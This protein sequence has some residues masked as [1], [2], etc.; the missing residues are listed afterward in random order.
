[1]PYEYLEEGV[2]SDATFRAS[3]RDLNEL[4]TAAADATTNLMVGDL[5]ALMP[6]TSVPLDVS[7]DALDLL[8]VRF[9]EEIVFEKDAHALFLRATDVHVTPHGRG[10]RAR[11][12]LRGEPIDPAKHELDADV[13]AVTLH[14][15]AVERGADGWHAQVTVDV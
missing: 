9:L 8:L 2:T 12:V 7:A 15:L 1:M 5:D 10:Y 13:K 14:G 4:F 11:A 3:G 6:R